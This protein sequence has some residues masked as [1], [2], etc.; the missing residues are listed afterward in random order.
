VFRVPVKMWLVHDVQK[1]PLYVAVFCVSSVP[2]TNSAF[3]EIVEREAFVAVLRRRVQSFDL[4]GV[5][6]DNRLF[7][8][9]G[10]LAFLEQAVDSMCT[11]ENYDVV[12]L[13]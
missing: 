9:L 8:E 13:N 3:E 7:G 4:V 6:I 10:I 1:A 5:V 12:Y 2:I 11:Q